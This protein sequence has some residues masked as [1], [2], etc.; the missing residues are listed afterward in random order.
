M[1]KCSG[2]SHRRK[3]LTF[4]GCRDKGSKWCHWSDGGRATRWSLVMEGLDHGQRRKQKGAKRKSPLSFLLF[5]SGS[6]TLP[7]IGWPQTE[8]CWQGN[9]GDVVLHRDSLSWRGNRIEKVG[10][11]QWEEGRLLGGQLKNN[12]HKHLLGARLPSKCFLC[13]KISVN[14]YILFH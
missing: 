8:G 10:D 3:A 6:L 4:L 13:I 12:Q 7:P 1:L 9:V 11:E 2:A 5:P 14:G